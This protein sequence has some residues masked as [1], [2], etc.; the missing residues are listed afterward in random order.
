MTEELTIQERQTNSKGRKSL[1]TFKQEQAI[2]CLY[3]HNIRATDIAKFFG[4]TNAAVHYHFRKFRGA[5]ITKLVKTSIK[6]I[7]KENKLL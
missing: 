3:K 4:L 7:L 6:G 5:N 2:L 1:L